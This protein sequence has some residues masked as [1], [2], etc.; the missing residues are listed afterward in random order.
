MENKQIKKRLLLK[1]SI[2]KECISLFKTILKYRKHP[3]I[4]LF[5]SPRHSNMGD[6]AQTY[7]IIRWANLNYPNHKVIILNYYISIEF[8]L[9]II[10]RYIKSNDMLFCHSGYHL[11]DLYLEKDIYC[12]V[13]TRF[14]EYKILVFPQTVNFVKDINV[15]N[16]VVSIFNKHG[17]IILC[18][19]DEI[20][21]KKAKEIF[22]NCKL[23]LYPDIVTSLIGSKCYKNYRK[24]IL[25]C[26]RNDIEA[27]YKP[28]QIHALKQKLISKTSVEQNDTT[29]KT[30]Y[31]Y[32]RNHREEVL[33]D[34]L[35]KFS[36][37][38][39][40]ITD[41][42][43]GTIFSLIAGTPVIVL[44]SSDHKLSSG[45]KWFPTSFSKY[46]YYADSLETAY[47]IANQILEDNTYEY[48]LPPYF[49]EKYYSKLKSIYE[50]M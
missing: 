7:C 17:N 12:K 10:K 35:N 43:H 21:Y 9:N 2:W 20:S 18:C 47:E 42:Y 32:I 48:N 23:L 30:P 8:I 4:Y 39:V 14:P 28:E 22:Y 46:V 15:L 24:G 31:E 40:V 29:I 19:R 41:R 44:S 50:T 3:I 49:E 6:Q 38:K 16:K 45:V 33:N 13:I 36:C 37:F 1:I 11:T 27:Y 5:G 34:I 26:M 25:F